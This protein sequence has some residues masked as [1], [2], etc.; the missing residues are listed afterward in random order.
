MFYEQFARTRTLGISCRSWT[1]RLKDIGLLIIPARHLSPLRDAFRLAVYTTHQ[2]RWNISML[3]LRAAR[4]SALSRDI[5]NIISEC[6]ITWRACR[7]IRE[8]VYRARRLFE[9]EREGERERGGGYS[10]RPQ[11]YSLRRTGCR[12]ARL[13]LTTDNIC[14]KS[15]RQ[16]LKTARAAMS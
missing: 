16:T 2:T 13:F 4:N 8:N 1:A 9:R 10:D 5:M 12:T 11:I 15:E 14:V 6:F 3:E 7:I